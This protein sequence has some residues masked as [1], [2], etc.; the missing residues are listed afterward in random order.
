MGLCYLLNLVLLVLLSAHWRL[1][2]LQSFTSSGVAEV[3]MRNLQVRARGSH[4]LGL[5]SLLAEVLLVQLLV[6]RI[7]SA[8][9][10]LPELG[11]LFLMTRPSALR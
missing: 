6:Q 2:L 10:A 5:L 4:L 7:A 3:Q 9:Q 8:S 11:F 1:P